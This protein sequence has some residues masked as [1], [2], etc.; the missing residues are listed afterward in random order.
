[1]PRRESC[2]DTRMTIHEPLMQAHVAKLTVKD[3]LALADAGSF[4]RYSRSELIEGE[5]WVVNAVHSTHAR[6]HAAMTVALGFALRDANLDLTLYSNPSTELAEDSLPEPDI[7]IAERG[8]GK[9]VSGVAV[10]LAVEISV[11]TLD[12]DLGRKQRLYAKYDVPEYWVV[13]AQAKLV[14]QFWGPAQD[15]YLSGHE[16]KFGEVISAA[17]I[18]NLRTDTTELL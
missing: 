11:S 12:F 7:V 6:L 10:R 17:T 13:D 9:L 14:R 16:F 2:Y 3:F 18:E 1:M 4:D 8:S 5:I 15:G